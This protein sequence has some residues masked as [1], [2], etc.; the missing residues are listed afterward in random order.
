MKPLVLRSLRPAVSAFLLLVQALGLGHVALAKHTLSDSGAVVEVTPLLSEKHEGRSEHLCA[1]EPATRAEGP[2]DCLVLS[3][4]RAPSLLAAAVAIRLERE[5]QTCR[6]TST[7]D[8][9]MQLDVLSRAPKA[10]PPQG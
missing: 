3:G 10:S 6:L 5:T 7:A 8:C 4:F 9:V 1:A 2:D